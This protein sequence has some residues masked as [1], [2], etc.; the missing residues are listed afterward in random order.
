MELNPLCEVFNIFHEKFWVFLS[1]HFPEI[2]SNYRT[3]CSVGDRSKE[4]IAQYTR[5]AQ[6][7]LDFVEGC[8]VTDCGSITGEMIDRFFVLQ[9][10]YTKYTVK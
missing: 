1:K 5:T 9:L 6:N 2:Y 4:S 10:C 8:G 3:H 7:F